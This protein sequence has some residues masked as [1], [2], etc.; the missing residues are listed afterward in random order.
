MK[1]LSLKIESVHLISADLKEI[2]LFEKGNGKGIVN[3]IGMLYWYFMR[4]TE[5]SYNVSLFQ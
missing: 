4:E 3:K 2:D 5:V 1:N